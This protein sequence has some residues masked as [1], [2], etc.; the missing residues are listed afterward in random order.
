MDFHNDALRSLAKKIGRNLLA[1]IDRGQQ[2]L[3]FIEGERIR[4][5]YFNGIRSS[6]A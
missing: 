4:A 1:A 6:R 5:N 3:N 2:T